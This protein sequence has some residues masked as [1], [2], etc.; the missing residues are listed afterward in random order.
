MYLGIDFLIGTGLRPF[1]VDVNLG[2]SGGAQEY[3]RT[4]IVRAGV[5]SGIFEDLDAVSRASYGK[6]FA[7]YLNS[8]AFLPELKSFKLWMDGEGLLPADI[9]P[10]LRLEDKWVQYRVLKGRVPMPASVPFDAA[11]KRAAQSLL[12]RCGSLVVKRRAGRGGLGFGIVRDPGSLRRPPDP[13]WP[14]LLQE[15]VDSRVDGYVFSLRAVVFAGRFLCA[16]AN[17]ARSAPTNRGTLAF[18]EPGARFGLTDRSFETV[19]FREKSWEAQIWF[20]GETPAHLARNL[21][22]VTVARASLVLPEA[23]WDEIRT[24]ALDIEQI[25]ETIVPAALPRAFFG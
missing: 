16:Y 6:P 4:F 2:L 12:E 18:V 22:E 21:F 3:D 10:I 11:H 20:G 7:A 1:V 19:S 15:P 17:L 23:L 24:E 5:P 25:Y 14:M 8:L 13:A 9:P